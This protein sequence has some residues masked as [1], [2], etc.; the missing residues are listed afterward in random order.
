ML[1]LNQRT[2]VGQATASQRTG[3]MIHPTQDLLLL[4]SVSSDNAGEAFLNYC[5]EQVDKELPGTTLELHQLLDRCTSTAERM[6]VGLSLVA[7]AIIDGHVA[8][9]AYQGS[10]WL[11]R[12]A[13]VGQILS[14][15]AALQILEGKTQAE[16]IYVMLTQSA[17]SLSPALPESLAKI[18]AAEALKLI[19]QPALREAVT[20]GTAEASMGVSVV[21]VLDTETQ[22]T[23]D[24]TSSLHDTTLPTAVT[25]SEVAARL[26]EQ[27]VEPTPPLRKV[28]QVVGG[29]V[30][31]VVKFY[32]A[33]SNEIEQLFSQDVYVR[34]KHRRSVGKVLAAM[35]LILVIIIGGFTLWK[36]NEAAKQQQVTDVLQPYR[37]QFNSF[38]ELSV[39][40]PVTARQQL[41]TFIVELEVRAQD[42]TQPQ[43]VQ[44]ALQAE[45][46]TVR[47]FN[48]SISGQTQLPLL[49]TFFDLRLVQSNFLASRIDVTSDT[50]FFLDSGQKKILA[51]NIERKQ[52]TILPVG[53]YPDI[54][55]MIA[56][57]EYLYFLGQGLF[58]FTLSGTEVATLVENSDD[59]TS[60]GQS[61]GL[62]GKYLYVLN[63]EQNN[64][65]RYDTEDDEL[66]SKP[67]GWIQPGQ[68][69][70]LST[71]QSFAIDGDVWLS[72]ETGEIKKL[73]SGRETAFTVT[74]LTEPLSSPITI[75]TKPELQNLYILESAKSRMVVLNK[76]GEFVKEVKSS[77]LAGAMAVVASEQHQKAFALSGSLVY[78]MGL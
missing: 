49:P 3:V 20:S 30:H 73:A 19:E 2:L 55:A 8:L 78:E 69:I 63:K 24:A 7:I 64:I 58:R 68:G 39:Q 65:F 33:I 44:Q 29:G 36:R 4:Y 72:T 38:K 11:K 59:I 37:Q 40:D 61:L 46:K 41:A 5:Q 17:S 66:D 75:F 42:T 56:D 32:S 13:K 27:P 15:E 50:L 62:F 6:S 67:V 25:P 77:E 23:D 14:A 26:S 16:D 10:V 60:A 28:G 54:R 21:T 31:G 18:T 12:G 57:D 76:E 74:G 52:P 43:H 1:R 34:Q 51:L 47:D 9:A 35:A 45:L 48:Q 71:V 53:E 22:T 70:D